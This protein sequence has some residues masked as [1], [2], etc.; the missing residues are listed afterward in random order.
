M[1]IATEYKCSQCNSI[2]EVYKQSIF[3]NFETSYR[4]PYCHSLETVRLWGNIHFDI[5]EG[6]VGTTKTGFEKNFTYN[7]SSIYGKYK[8]KKI[9]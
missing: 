4:C 8:G 6:L 7:H 2:F 3:D 5:A 1:A 9:K